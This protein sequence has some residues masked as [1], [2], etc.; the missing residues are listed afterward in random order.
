MT[1]GER[2][3]VRAKISTLFREANLFEDRQSEEGREKAR[4]LRLQ[5]DLLNQN[6]KVRKHE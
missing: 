4:E 1:R 2:Y 5:A 6:L 3:A